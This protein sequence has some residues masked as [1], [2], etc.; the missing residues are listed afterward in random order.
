LNQRSIDIFEQTKKLHGEQVAIK[1][2]LD[3]VTNK[4]KNNK[5]D[6]V[7]DPE[8]VNRDNWSH[9]V[10]YLGKGPNGSHVFELHISQDQTVIDDGKRLDTILTDV[11]ANSVIKS[12]NSVHKRIY[13]S[14]SDEIDWSLLDQSGMYQSKNVNVQTLYQKFKA[15]KAD[16][17]HL[18][19]L[20]NN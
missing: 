4:N 11:V 7:R 16:P 19:S 14:K 10:K 9:M 15:I 2:S 13:E 18:V 8:L 17:N 5:H 1:R 20:V 3:L 6:W 12:Q